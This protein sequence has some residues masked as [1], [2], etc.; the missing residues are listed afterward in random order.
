MKKENENQNDVDVD[1]PIPIVKA[2][3]ESFEKNPEL[4]KLSRD[5]IINAGFRCIE[6]GVDPKTWEQYF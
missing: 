1:E 2:I 6:Q 4:L 3:F 5:E